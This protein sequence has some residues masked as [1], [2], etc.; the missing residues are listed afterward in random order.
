[1]RKSNILSIKKPEPN[2]SQLQVW[3]VA[4]F[5]MMISQIISITIYPVE[6]LYKIS[7]LLERKFTKMV[8]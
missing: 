6:K 8:S 2:V 3:L 5:N 1:M 7:G 4:H